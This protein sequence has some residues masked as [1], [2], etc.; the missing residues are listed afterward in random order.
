MVGAGMPQRYRAA[1]NGASFAVDTLT[2]EFAEAERA[3]DPAKMYG[4]AD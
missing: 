1:G 2:L 4:K 3:F